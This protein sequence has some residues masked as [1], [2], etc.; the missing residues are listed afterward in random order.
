MK[1]TRIIACLIIIALLGCLLLSSGCKKTNSLPGTFDSA[2][3]DTISDTI[4]YSD[5]SSLSG[6]FKL[7]DYDN[8]PS[9]IQNPMPAYPEQ[10]KSSGIQGVVVLEVEITKDGVVGEVKIIKSL[11]AGE[12][13]LDE[14]AAASVK[15]WI[16]KPA[17]RKNKPV[18]S[19][20]N[21]PIPFSLKSGD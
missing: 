5:T 4:D 14:T 18:A 1:Q 6:D 13:A 12:G 9:P 20:V 8:P 10:Y 7:T 16:F 19:R 17:L 21:I 11:L 15:N 3:L 2:S